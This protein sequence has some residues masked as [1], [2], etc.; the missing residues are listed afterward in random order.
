[1]TEL[2]IDPAAEQALHAMPNSFD[3]YRMIA[4][5]RKT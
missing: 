5:T 3:F 2:L 4:A 1:M